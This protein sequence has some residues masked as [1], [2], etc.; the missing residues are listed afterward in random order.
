MN[1]KNTFILLIV[2]VLIGLFLR[3]YN[4]SQ[5]LR[6]NADQ[7]RDA[8]IAINAAEG[9]TSWPLLGPMAGGTDFKLGGIFYHFQIVAVKIFGNQP[10]VAAFPD[11]LFAVLSIPLFFLLARIFFNVNVSLGITWLYVISYFMVKYGR[12]A[13]NPNSTP[14]FVML[15]LYSFYGM[16]NEGKNKQVW[17][18]ILCGVALGINVQLHTSLL[19]ILPVISVLVLALLYDRKYVKI[20][21]IA[22]VLAAAAIVNIPQIKSEIETR[23]ANTTK[24]FLGATEK[25][26][27]NASLGENALLNLSCHLKSNAH[28]LTAKG[29][30]DVC[31][32]NA[33][34]KIVSKLDGKRMTFA[35]K[36]SFVFAWILLAVF[37]LGGYFLL[38]RLA[39]REQDKKKKLMLIVLS[40]YVGISFLLF[41]TWATEL[42]VRFFLGLSFVPFLLL[43]LWL[44]FLA[45]KFKREKVFIVIAILMLS[46]FNWQKIYGT[47]EDLEN[48]GKEINGNFDYAT[49]GEENFIMKFMLENSEGEKTLYLDAQAGYLFKM[50]RPL[51]FLGEK[52][53]LTLVQMEKEVSLKKGARIF[54]LKSADTGC[55]LAEKILD[56]Y[57]VEKCSE[58]GQFSVFSLK[59]K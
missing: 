43:G 9:K 40:L 56:K 44:T 36:F 55:K 23:G 19:I 48:G 30:E 3:S 49:L 12:F 15:Y 58:R 25:N 1:K 22:I 28:I 33:D 47:F 27:R 53:G 39:L 20:G 41:C 5:W 17:W 24:F 31:D 59:L 21:T 35:Q 32:Y 18:A 37:S 50:L 7:S 13:W 16:M 42:S 8:R 45:E 4:F 29:D 54:Y 2:F 26:V 46:F 52:H 38:G 6:F 34:A 10:Y 51:Q 11:L 57:E 14:F